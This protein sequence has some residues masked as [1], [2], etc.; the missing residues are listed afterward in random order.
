VVETVVALAHRLGMRALAEGVERP[1]QLRAL[2]HAQCD[3]FQGFSFARPMPADEAAALLR[4]RANEPN[5]ADTD[6]ADRSDDGGSEWAVG[7]S[8]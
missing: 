1:E 2:R 6:A 4:F 5:R 7:P 3:L 8:R